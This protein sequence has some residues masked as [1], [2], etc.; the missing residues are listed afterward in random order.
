MNGDITIEYRCRDCNALAGDDYEDVCELHPLAGVYPCPIIPSDDDDEPPPRER[1]EQD[2]SGT[3]A[4]ELAE[5]MD[6]YRKLK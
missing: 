5:R 4:A 1:D 2:Y 6:G 3:S